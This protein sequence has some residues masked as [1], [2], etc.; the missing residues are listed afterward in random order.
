MTAYY[1]PD[2]NIGL[3]TWIKR[4]IL[5]VLQPL[6]GR[7]AS[8]TALVKATG[9]DVV[10]RRGAYAVPALEGASA[11]Q[12]DHMRIVKVATQ[13]T[14]TS[15][16]ASVPIISAMGGEL[17]NLDA[18]T[19][20]RWTP[21]I[22]GLEPTCT[23]ESLTGATTLTIPGSIRRIAMLDKLGISKSTVAGDVFRT[24]IGAFPAAVLAW[25]RG[26]RGEA[27]ATD[28]R[29]RKM[30]FRLFI[31]TSHSGSAEERTEEVDAILDYVEATL[32]GRS[33][34]DG[35]IFADPPIAV[36]DSGVYTAEDGSYVHFVEFDL[37]T[38]ITRIEHRTFVDWL[39]TQTQY[40]TDPTPEYA[41]REEAIKLLDLRHTQ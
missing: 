35:E 15:A 9:A 5:C 19:T 16:G 36:G 14:V 28:A 40:F 25:T 38:T 2:L 31:V 23:V 10:L 26:S 30:R 1:G 20:L 18:N 4:C 17:Q 22:P 33:A 37:S 13:T 11:R 34:V 6:T 32:E 21:A 24:R 12:T 8:G 7:R 41:A 3:R 39:E 29:M 27:V